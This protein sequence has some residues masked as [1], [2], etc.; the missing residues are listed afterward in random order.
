MI[1]IS[2]F[3]FLGGHKDLG[4]PARLWTHLSY[5]APSISAPCFAWYGTG[6]KKSVES[7]CGTDIRATALVGASA[8]V[9]FL[10]WMTN[11]RIEVVRKKF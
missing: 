9:K 11:K 7:T 1:T 3:T 10:F 8:T 6:G 4:F 2:T 5:R